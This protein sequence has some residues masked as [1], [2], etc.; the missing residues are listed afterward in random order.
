MNEQDIQRAVE[1]AIA[2]LLQ[3]IET[4]GG[5]IAELE[6][7]LGVGESTP[8]IVQQEEACKLLGI[9]L[10]TLQRHRQHWLEGV[11]WWREGISDR[12][13]Y[14]LPLIRDGQRRGFDSVAHLNA[15]E[16]W[17]KQ[18]PSNKKKAV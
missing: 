10:R 17:A 5:K 14:N 11:H 6:Q 4:L 13:L 16:A 2:P 15:C 12:P 9:S 8:E 3:H 1:V 7:K 18:Q